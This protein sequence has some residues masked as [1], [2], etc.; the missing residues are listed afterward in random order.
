MAAS[1]RAWWRLVAACSVRQLRSLIHNLGLPFGL[2][3]GGAIAL[4]RVLVQRPAWLR[5]GADACVV[6]GMLVGYAAI[7]GEHWRFPPHQAMDWLPVLAIV[8]FFFCV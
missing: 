4:R 2:A 7:Y 8:S 3:F 5:W 1:L 6:A